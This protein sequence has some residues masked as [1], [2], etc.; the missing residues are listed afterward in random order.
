M[1]S[2]LANTQRR[3]WRLLT[4]P[5]GVRAALAEAGDPKGDSLR[6]L[7]RGDARGSAALRL[8]VYANA[9]F[10]RI[11]D[12]LAEDYG[13]L[14]AALCEEGFHDLVT[15]YLLVHPPERPSLRDAGARL[16][17]FLA[18]APEA[19]PF[20]RRW[21][22]AGDLAQLEWAL[23]DAFDAPDA[24]PLTAP[25]LAKLPPADWEALVLPLHPSAALLHLEHPVHHLREAFEA[26]GEL[27][28]APGPE[29]TTAL[30]WRRAERVLFRALA[31]LEAEL[32]ERA[33]RGAPFGALCQRLAESEG[34]SE[35]PVRAASLLAAWV[36]AGLIARD[37]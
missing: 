17:R 20:R 31:P 7:V 5:S 10:Y 28:T 16:P 25:E 15:A 21:P 37:P 18:S 26:D 24:S 4:A 19:A 8:E 29:A 23:V 13:A 33:S 6:D 30:V 36:E 27:P 35:A 32:L 34:E 14:R 2:D 11:H 22:F 3:L 1:T 12:V 9:Y